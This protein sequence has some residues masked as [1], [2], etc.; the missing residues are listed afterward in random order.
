MAAIARAAPESYV[1]YAIERAARLGLTRCV[2]HLEVADPRI[3]VMRIPGPPDPVTQKVSD[4]W[5]YDGAREWPVG[6]L[7]DELRQL[8]VAEIWS[9]EVLLDRLSS[10]WTPQVWWV[11]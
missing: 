8:S 1:F 10:G 9:H 11:R 4:W 3:P 6:A 7:T 5:L 2:A